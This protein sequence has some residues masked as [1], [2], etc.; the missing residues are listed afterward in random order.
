MKQLESLFRLGQVSTREETRTAYSRD[1]SKIHGV[2]QAVVWPESIDDIVH[3]IHWAKA[4]NADLVP[5]GAG[6]GLCGGATPQDSIV[7]DTSRL[8][9]MSKLNLTSRQVTVGAGLPLDQLNSALKPH[10]LFLPVIPGSHRAATIGGM[11]ATNAAGLHAVCFG[12]MA[13]WIEE[14]VLV[15][16]QSRIRHISNDE[17]SQVAGWE[18]LSGMIVQITLRLAPIIQKTS[19][20]VLTF[21]RIREMLDLVHQLVQHPTLSALEYINPIASTKIGWAAK[22]T[23][24]VEYWS[25]EGEI[26]DPAQIVK[27]WKARESLSAFLTQAGFPISEDPQF[28]PEA[29]EPVLDWLTEQAVPVFGHLGVGILHPRFLPNDPRIVELYHQVLAAGGKI[30]GEHGMGLKKK[31]WASEETKENASALKARY[32]PQGIFNRGKVC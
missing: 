3:L 30:S 1:A 9:Q 28:P 27:I 20:S 6:T 23:I 8:C 31:Q 4:T 15:D 19:V 14:L 11:V 13:D 5:R 32:D 25:E 10:G 21:D 16:G 2:C 12:R 18:G 17:L 7:I 29:Q 22:Q 24:L 26:T